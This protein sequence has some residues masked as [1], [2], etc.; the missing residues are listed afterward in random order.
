MVVCS[1]ATRYTCHPCRARGGRDALFR[2]SRRVPPFWTDCVPPRRIT[3]WEEMHTDPKQRSSNNSVHAPQDA[4][5]STAQQRGLPQGRNR[6]G[7]RS[8]RACVRARARS[9]EIAKK[10]AEVRTKENTVT[11]ASWSVKGRACVAEERGRAVRS[12]G[13]GTQDRRV[14]CT[15]VV[16]GC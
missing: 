9:I 1:V 3:R 6:E 15:W 13:G 8:A 14:G 11:S 16:C 5:G 10:T 4:R 2:V 12:G 7:S